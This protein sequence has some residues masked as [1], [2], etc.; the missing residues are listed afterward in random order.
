MSDEKEIVITVNETTVVLVFITTVLACLKDG[1][2]MLIVAPNILMLMVCYERI[3]IKAV[4]YLSWVT[5]VIAFGA[6]IY[7]QFSG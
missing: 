5:L 3:K 1:S 2:T 4:K 7:R 6:V